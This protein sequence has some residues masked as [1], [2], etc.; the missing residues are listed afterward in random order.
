V[1]RRRPGRGHQWSTHR[2]PEE[3]GLAAIELAVVLPL[4]IVVVFGAVE[5]SIAYRRQHGLYAAANEGARAASDPQ[6]TTVE[7][8]RRVRSA[9][10]SVMDNGDIKNMTVTVTPDSNQPCDRQLPGTHVVVTV[11]APHQLS[12]PLF[13]NE[14]LTLTGRGEFPCA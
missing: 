9:L 5:L 3:G 2:E 4:L 12:V 1:K 14:S 7:V 8:D 6:T 10:R 13:E 11:S